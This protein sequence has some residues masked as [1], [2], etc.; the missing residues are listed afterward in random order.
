[1]LESPT[2]QKPFSLQIL[3]NN[4][5]PWLTDLDQYFLLQLMTI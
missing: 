2:K 5:L 1:M 3:H 4:A